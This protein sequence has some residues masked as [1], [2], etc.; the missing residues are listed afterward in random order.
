M[1][2]PRKSSSSPHVRAVQLH[3]TRTPAL[4]TTKS[5]KTLNRS[6]PPK[7]FLPATG[8]PRQ[9]PQPHPA[10]P[11][12]QTHPSQTPPTESK[13]PSRSTSSFSISA[14]KLHLNSL[15]LQIGSNWQS[16]ASPPGAFH[17]DSACET[18]EF[19]NFV[20]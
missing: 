19:Q 10:H 3:P 7:R 4:P 2:T 20:V 6:P 9:S 17:P 16:S 11:L 8:P 5:P 13:R 12:L 15:Q 18:I 1:A 14:N